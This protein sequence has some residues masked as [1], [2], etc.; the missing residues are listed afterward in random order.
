MLPDDLEKHSG[1]VTKSVPVGCRT[2]AAS[3]SAARDIHV[4][5]APDQPQRRAHP[6]RWWR[7]LTPP[8][9]A[10]ATSGSSA[11]SAI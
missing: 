9:R 10:G 1:I 7:M 5:F 2:R 3:G 6:P 4:A 11:S 8:N